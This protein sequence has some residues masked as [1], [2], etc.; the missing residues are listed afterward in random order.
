MTEVARWIGDPG[1]VLSLTFEPVVAGLVAGLDTPDVVNL[2]TA[3]MTELNRWAGAAGE[4]P[5]TLA[6]NLSGG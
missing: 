2:D 4:I 5:Q 6:R 3:T 1:S